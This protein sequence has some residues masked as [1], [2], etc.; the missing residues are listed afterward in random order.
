[1]S[2]IF[3]IK[4]FTL[5]E[6]TLKK[7]IHLDDFSWYELAQ[8]MSIND[9]V[10]VPVGS[11]EEHGPHMP[12]GTDYMIAEADAAVLAERTGTYVAPTMV[13]G[14]AEMLM[15]FPGTCTITPEL[16]TEWAIDVA[17]NLMNFG[18]KKI[19]FLNGHGGNAQPLRIA[20]DILYAKY[21][22]LVATS[23]W[24]TTLAQISEHSCADHG[25]RYETSYLMAACGED[26][27]IN[28]AEAKTLPLNNPSKNIVHESAEGLTFEGIP[29]HLAW[30]IQKAAPR[31]N[32]G[33]PAEEANLALGQDMR[34]IYLDFMTDL[35]LSMKKAVL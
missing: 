24:W 18:T 25:G 12:L 1:M 32:M 2:K 7:K 31:G 30:T 4:I 29:V 20:G 33:C 26:C 19:L 11:I 8:A 15:D 21:G 17:E 6:Y 14:D 22:I 13:I 27:G 35:I 23:E 10:I 28:M 34:R 16:L 9:M 5:E 3:N